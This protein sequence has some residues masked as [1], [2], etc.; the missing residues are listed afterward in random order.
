[1]FCV[2]SFTCQFTHVYGRVSFTRKSE[3]IRT[4]QKCNLKLTRG[5]KMEKQEIS[6]FDLL[7]QT[8]VGLKRQGP[9][10]PEMTIR[11]LRYVEHL[12]ENSRI[13]DLGCGT[14]GQTMVLAQNTTGQITGVDMIPE[15]IDVFNKNTKELHLENR[16]TGIVG[17]VEELPFEQEE[18]DLIWSEGV[19]DGIGFEK[20]LTYWNQFLKKDGYV[21][22]TCPSWFTDERPS[23][24]D[25][26]WTDAGSGLDTVEQNLSA[27]KK[28]GYQF[29]A[30]F[31]L[32]ETC[33]TEQYFIPREEAEKVLL[34][35]YAGDKTVAAYIEG[36]Q[37]EVELYNKY[38]QQYGYV[39]YIGKKI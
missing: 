15:F 8:H 4:K 36:D 12:D 14:G 34:Q 18:L 10:S 24:V 39:F 2:P 21:A 29:V 33:W 23:E 9:G 35:K 11:A 17:S 30:A 27:L 31:I 7:I 1:M 28:A 37:Y 19:I 6:T 20:G 16:V 5:R 22:V 25:K 13:A 32:P 26:F 38:K 3:I